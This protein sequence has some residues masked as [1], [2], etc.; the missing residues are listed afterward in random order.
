[1]FTDFLNQAGSLG[2]I[3]NPLYAHMACGFMLLK[4]LCRIF[5]HSYRFGVHS[6]GRVRGMK[7]RRKIN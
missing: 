6:H 4:S 5:L 2:A 1:M 3:I 7:M